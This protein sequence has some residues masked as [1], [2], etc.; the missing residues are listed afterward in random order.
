MSGP[1][2]SGIAVLAR[3]VSGPEGLRTVVVATSLESTDDAVGRVRDAL[4]VGG[5]LAVVV[6]AA[7]GWLLATAA[8]RPVE[9]MRRQTADISE[10]DSRSRLQVPATRDE[11]AALAVTMNE[12]LGR[13]HAAV[14]RQ[15]AFVADARPRAADAAGGAQN[16]VGARRPA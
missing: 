2:A 11:I 7:G 9:R 6:A 15:R 12:L 4:L 1:K 14:D 10:H 5:A 3:S 13:L 16:R 8:L